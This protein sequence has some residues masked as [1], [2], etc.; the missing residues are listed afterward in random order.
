MVVNAYMTRQMIVS[1]IKITTYMVLDMVY[2]K[3]ITI[4]AMS[5]PCVLMHMV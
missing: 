5:R 2:I 4:M 3:S 1:Y